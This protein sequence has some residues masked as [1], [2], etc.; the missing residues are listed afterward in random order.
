MGDIL[1]IIKKQAFR[2]WRV[3]PCLAFEADA[4]GSTC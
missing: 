3:G 4:V 1:F 2:T